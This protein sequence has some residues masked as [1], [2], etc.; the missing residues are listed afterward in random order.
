MKQGYRAGYELTL[1]LD[2]TSGARA[3]T[4]RETTR[5]RTEK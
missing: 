2:D 3:E 1:G 5:E 4:G